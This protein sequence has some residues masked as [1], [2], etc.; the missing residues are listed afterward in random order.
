MKLT[1]AKKA[2]A[3]AVCAPKRLL[4]AIETDFGG[5]MTRSLTR[6]RDILKP[7]ISKKKRAARIK[8]RRQTTNETPPVQ[9]T[10]RRTKSLFD[11]PKAYYCVC[12]GPDTGSL[13]VWCEGI[14]CQIEWYHVGCLKETI[15]YELPWICPFCR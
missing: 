4:I 2:A 15:N 14:G 6:A 5:M 11:Q 1:R 8:M 3:E 7:K 10:A 13:M 12:R 9:R